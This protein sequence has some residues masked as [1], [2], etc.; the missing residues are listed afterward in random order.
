M[1][2][3]LDVGLDDLAAPSRRRADAITRGRVAVLASRA[4]RRHR[5][6]G[7]RRAAWTILLRLAHAWAG[8]GA[9]RAGK[10]S[11][12]ECAQPDRPRAVHVPRGSAARLSTLA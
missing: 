11:L 12:V 8:R 2:R 9:V 1:E 10:A 4:A 3:P 7:R 5:R 6:D